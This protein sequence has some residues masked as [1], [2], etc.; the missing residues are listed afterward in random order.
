MISISKFLKREIYFVLCVYL[1][2]FAAVV[3]LEYQ[4]SGLEMSMDQT[5][6]YTD[7]EGENHP[8][9]DSHSDK[10]IITI[11][12]KP[13]LP[14]L[15]PLF[16]YV[17]ILI[18]GIVY[19]VSQL[20]LSVDDIK[21][22][23]E[24]A[25]T[26]V[27]TKQPLNHQYKFSE[28]TNL[29]N[30]INSNIADINAN[31]LLRH[32]YVNYV[33]HDIKTPL[34]IINGYIEILKLND[35]NETYTL[36]IEQQIHQINSIVENNTFV[37]GYI[38]NITQLDV[39][40]TIEL[41]QANYLQLYSNLQFDVECPR[42]TTW[43]VDQSGFIRCIQNLVDNG[44]SAQTNSLLIKIIV[45]ERSIE[46]IDHGCGF[47]NTKFEH[48]L[49]KTDIDSLHYGLKITNTICLANNLSLSFT[50]TDSGTIATI[51]LV[52]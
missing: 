28:L 43:L 47:D 3:A 51:K 11:Y 41:L 25:I 2:S 32:Q 45:A 21:R 13:V 10:C 52:D 9:S 6:E 4:I 29:S 50:K 15:I 35:Y 20:K 27:S 49:H 18:C 26:V 38:P 23:E 40:R 22:F 8:V 5:N 39:G 7:C 31:D 19:L 16:I 1:L 24:N 30:E 44:I 48:Y 17:V 37:E 34:H 14:F 12:H 42:H 33:M 46:I 36:P